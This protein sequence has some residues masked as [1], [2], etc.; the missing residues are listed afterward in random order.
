MLP[1]AGTLYFN[2]FSLSALR[3]LAEKPIKSDQNLDLWN[4]LFITFKLMREGNKFLKVPY[5]NGKLFDDNLLP[6]IN[7]KKLRLSNEI[8]LKVIKLL[9]T[10]KEKNIRQRI[11]FLEISEE[12]IGAIYESLLDF[13]PYISPSNEF[14]LIYTTTERKSTG[15]YYTPKELIDIL[16]KTT[17]QPLV[18]DRLD[19]AGTSTADKIKAILDIK[20]CDPACG[21]GTFLLSA[22]DYLG[23]RLAEIRTGLKNPS[24]HELRLARRDVLQHCIYGVDK[25]PLAVEL[26]KMSLWLRACV[27]DKPLN[28][29]DNH[30]KCGNSLVGFGQKRDIKFINP[31][32]FKAIPGNKS[33]GIEGENKALAAQARN[34]IKKEIKELKKGG[35][36]TRLSFFLTESKTSD[37]C[38]IEFQKI[39]EM[40]EDDPRSIKSKEKKY[41]KIR[42]F[43]KYK[44]AL[45]E[46]NIWTAAYFWP[47]EGEKLGQIPTMK[48]ISELREG[49][50]SSSNAKLLDKINKIAKEN[51][52]FHWFIEFPEVFSKRRQGFD[53]ILGNP[54]WEVVQLK[55]REF[56]IGLDN[57][58]INAENQA[59]RRALIKSLKKRNY[60]IFEHYKNSFLKIKKAGL[61]F[62]NS[63][64]YLFTARGTL[65]T[66][67]LF[68]ERAYELISQR[69]YLGFVLPTGIIMNYYTPEFFIKLIK[70]NSVL[71][72]F[73]FENEK[74]IFKI[75]R[76]LRFC[77][78]SIGGKSISR[79]II[80]MCFYRKEPVEIQN[81]LTQLNDNKED[82]KQFLEHLPNN[83][84]MLPIYKDDFEL[85]NPNT[86]TCPSFRNKKD[87][88]IMKKIYKNVPILIKRNPKNKDLI[89]NPWNIQFSRMLD[90]ANDSRLFL[91]TDD[92]IKRNII[93]NAKNI[94]KE[95]DKIKENFFPVYE[96][97]MIW[98]Y[99]H[100]ASV[101]LFGSKAL[102]KQNKT[103]TEQHQDPQFTILP[104]YWIEK[105]HVIIRIPKDYKN[106]WLY[107]FRNVARG[108]DERTFIS[109]IIPISGAAHSLPLIYS[110]SNIKKFSC[111]IANM[112]SFVLDYCLRQ[113]LS[114]ANMSYFIIEQLPV[115][116]PEIYNEKLT[117]MICERVL[118]LIFTAYDLKPFAR[119]L[120]YSGPPFKWDPEKRA[121]LQAELDAIFFHLYKIKRTDVEYILETFQVLKRKEIEKFNEFKTKRLILEAY[122]YYQQHREIF[123]VQ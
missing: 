51:Q 24:E 91:T 69:G 26:A 88:L 117:T 83:H 53:C 82:L 41:K 74:Q 31:K 115:F 120:G 7:G 29:L 2:Q 114:G 13:K 62:I 55:E 17:L 101:P 6:I 1:S 58:I 35:K 118:E 34:I 5:Y 106:K 86:L 20:I 33:T 92:L 3:I 40:P 70:N 21:G 89:L 87:L 85:F 108:N 60:Q 27:K 45:N 44:Q 57:K 30:I 75:M 77:L 84:F 36:I 95:F 102:H 52:F 121:K 98:H 10:T 65:N 43:S 38:S 61:F 50:E 94:Q 37:I 64:F 23:E 46:A 72:I 22:L 25:N 96:G 59:K 71:S 32:A 109:T 48:L 99:D 16:I 100:R 78:F 54:P 28:Y 90:M 93:K 18:R 107:G 97:K 119:D 122:D 80:P 12:E 116:P 19:S 81:F 103:T 111:L 79:E 113:K 104:L 14:K 11:N 66:Y 68:T 112:N 67:A 105:D 15:S 4:K 47:F 49:V 73:D 42:C 123:E 8:C 56:F 39:I 76:K 110:N 9:T 63:N